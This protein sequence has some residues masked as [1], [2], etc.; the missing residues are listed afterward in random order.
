ASPS[1]RGWRPLWLPTASTVLSPLSYTTL[2]R[3]RHCR[4][5]SA[6]GAGAC[7]GHRQ[8]S[9]RQR[10][11]TPRHQGLIVRPPGLQMGPDVSSTYLPTA[12]DARYLPGQAYPPALVS[13]AVALGARTG[14]TSIHHITG[15]RN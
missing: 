3:S 11:R 1:T 9:R 2:F 14:P 15:V 13:S 8:S 7:L 6:S 12:V 10:L 5:S 4:G